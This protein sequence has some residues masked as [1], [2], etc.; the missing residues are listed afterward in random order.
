VTNSDQVAAVFEK[1][2]PTLRKPLRGFV[3]CAGLSQTFAAVDYPISAF[4]RLFDINVTG[5]FAVAQAAAREMMRTGENG[6]M[7]FVASMSGYVVNK[8]SLRLSW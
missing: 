6:S 3:A 1:F 2:L 4:R 7:V 8:V 5:I